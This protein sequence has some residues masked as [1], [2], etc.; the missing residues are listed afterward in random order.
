MSARLGH[1]RKRSGTVFAMIS[2]GIAELVASSALIL[3]TF[4]G[5]EAGISTNRTKRCLTPV[6]LGFGPQIQIYYL[7]AF[8]TAD[9]RPSRCT[10]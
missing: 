2:L 8:W 5:G 7:I 6:R 3:R 9:L 1:R 10:P 4:F